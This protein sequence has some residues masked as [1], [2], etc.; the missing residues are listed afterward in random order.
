MVAPRSWDPLIVTDWFWSW[1]WD[2]THAP[3]LCEKA[4]IYIR[5]F[6]GRAGQAPKLAHLTWTKERASGFG[7]IMVRVWGRGEGSHAWAEIL[8]VWSSLSAQR[9]PSSRLLTGL[10]N[11]GTK[12]KAWEVSAIKHTKWSQTITIHLWCFTDDWIMPYFVSLHLNLFK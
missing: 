6:L 7:F 1:G 10:L 4:I 12:G 9:E 3:R 2:T 11:C 5:G 8:M